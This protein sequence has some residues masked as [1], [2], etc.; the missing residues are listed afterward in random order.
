[1]NTERIKIL[2]LED[3]PTDADQ[4]HRV[5]KKGLVDFEVRVVDSKTDFTLMLDEFNPDLVISDH[6]LP[7]FNSLE[8]LEILKTKGSDIPF[9]L[10][11]GAVSEEFAAQIIKNGADDY[12]LKDHPQRLPKAVI[13]ALD[14]CRLNK[15]LQ[16]LTHERELLASIV[17]FSNDAI[18]SKTLDGIITS[19]NKSAERIYGYTAAEMIG[20]N[21]SLLYFPGRLQ[22]E[23]EIMEKIKR[24]EAVANFETVRLTKT[25]KIVEISLSTSPLKDEEGR[26][27][28]VGHISRDISDR[29]KT[30]REVLESR[31][32]Y[33]E[34]LQNLSAAVYTCDCE[35]KIV[36]F[37]KAAEELWGRTPDLDSDLWCGSYQMADLDGTPVAREN[38]A[39]AQTVRQRK[40]PASQEIR[41][42]RPDGSVRHV[43]PNP[44]PTFDLEG[45]LT[46]AINMLMDVTEL[47]QAGQAA[48]NAKESLQ[49]IL[50]QS[51]DAIC[52]MNAN[53]EFET[54]SAACYDIWGYRPEEMIGRHYHDFIYQEDVPVSITAGNA[55][56]EGEYLTNF[57]NRYV[58]KDGS[59][60]SMV[61]AASRDEKNNRFYCIARNGTQKKEAEQKIIASEKR[62]R[63]LIENSTDMQTL[64]LPDGTLIYASPSIEKI[65]GYTTEEYLKQPAGVTVHPE[66]LPIL[67][68]K[69][70]GLLN[71][72]GGSFYNQHRLRHK[73]GRWI[74]TEGN[75]T[76]MLHEPSIAALV[77]NFRD[78][79][80]RRIAEEKIRQS[81]ANLRQIVDL[82]PHLIFVKDDAGRFILVNKRFA[83][84]YGVSNTDILE[85]EKV[86]QYTPV[87]SEGERFIQEDIEVI[88][89]GVKKIIPDTPFTDF[90]GNTYVF[91]TTKVPYTIAGTG[92]KAVLG[93]SMDVTE[94]RK[95]AEEL[96]NE[97]EKLKAIIE[98]MNAG[99]IVA[100]S[101][102]RFVFRNDLAR[103][104][105]GM[106][107]EKDEIEKWSLKFGVYRP[108]KITVFPPE[109]L[110][111]AK[112]IQGIRT[113]KEILYVKNHRRPEGAYLSVSGAP[114][115]NA[116]GQAIY[117]VTVFRDVTETFTAS[118]KLKE[119]FDAL[120]LASEMQ[121]SILDALPANIALLDKDG[122]IVEVNQA[123]KN[124]GIENSLCSPDFNIN[125]NYIKI[126]AEAIGIEREEGQL[127]AEGIKKVINGDIPGFHLEYP[128]HSPSEKRWF[129]AEVAPLMKEH[130]KGAVVMHINISARKLAELA[131]QELNERLEEKV[132]ERTAQ[133]EGVNQEL[134]AFSYSVSHDLRAPLRA[135]NGYSKILEEDFAPVLDEEGNRL[136]KVIQDSA[137]RMNTL[138]DD[139]L[140]FSKLGRQSLRKTAIPMTEL[141]Q[142]TLDELR[143]ITNHRAEIKL[144]ELHPVLADPALMKH[145]IMNLLSNA[146]KYSSQTKNPKIEIS[147]KSK[148]T[149]I[150]YCIKDNGVG[151]DMQY[152]DKLFGV[153]QRLHSSDQFEGTGVGLAIVQRIIHRHGGRV[154]AEGQVGK[155]ASFYF[156]LPKNKNEIFTDD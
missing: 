35:G 24:G 16:N 122:V 45:N 53:G 19:W 116:E 124:Y 110:P 98:N 56:R 135:I 8:A 99:L 82:V 127:M 28:G 145:V 31:N 83:E 150:V 2:H 75:M 7:S 38:N 29:K 107:G 37:N 51:I 30:E 59:I 100:D 142:D 103:E 41:I 70:K 5:L 114:I 14:K 10:V 63:A 34:L 79:S 111:M 25:G 55:V 118:E 57:E 36:L 136:L 123:W 154:W 48:L 119:S 17:N 60:V 121:S 117:G 148:K 146:V 32:Q 33:A 61:W 132:T 108:D 129:K 139:L 21:I 134:E 54:M 85:G 71:S 140:A 130:G 78:I 95:A 65:L 109:E 126:S 11:T 105:F 120:Q 27:I 69:V 112:A 88:R 6:S 93:I 94:S 86:E 44:V 3:T 155:G 151:F 125:D 91:H 137:E 43:I 76:N 81:E 90:K 128:C 152:V 115:C 113:D 147:S 26:I 66:D 97:R 74:W 23:Q 13:N 80:D 101:E 68:K 40:A 131:L 46:G 92:Q 42:I 153:F 156:S 104:L 22:E 20:Q 12:I 106:D 49:R 64:A 62:F 9:I 50:D 149:E 87:Y 133:L 67:L 138:I 52:T 58:R 143:R 77:S 141:M 89:S 39:L 96:Y 1:M 15:K 73:N 84:L 47:K 144:N 72:P 4:V 18:I 102:G